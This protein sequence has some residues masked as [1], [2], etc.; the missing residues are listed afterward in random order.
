MLPGPTLPKMS[1]GLMGL[2]GQTLLPW[3]SHCETG[4]AQETALSQ[5]WIINK[6]GNTEQTEQ[7]PAA[8]TGSQT[9]AY[10]RTSLQL[11]LK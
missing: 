8:D 10:Y 9:S 6:Y 1:Q 3:V 5:N 4:S 7:A 2:Q 11:R